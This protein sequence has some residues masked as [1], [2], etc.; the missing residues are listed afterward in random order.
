M[1][2]LMLSWEYPPRV[3]G[4]LGSH[5]AGLSRALAEVGVDVS[6]LTRGEIGVQRDDNG[7]H[8]VEVPLWG[9]LPAPEWGAWVAQ[10]NI[11]YL[12]AA[13]AQWAGDPPDLLHAHDWTVALTTR[14]LKHL[15]HRPLIATIHATEAGRNGGLSSP[16]NRYIDA[17]ERMLTYEA[18]RVIV[19]SRAMVAEVQA[20]FH[21]PEEKLAVIP[22]GVSL[23]EQNEF[24]MAHS[25]ATVLYM[26]RLTYE[27]GIHVLID[28]I[29]QIRHFFPD[30]QLLIAGDGPYRAQ[31]EAQAKATLDPQQVRFIGWVNGRQKSALLSQAAI[32]VV[33]SL[34]EPFGIVALEEMGAALPVVASR[35]GGLPEVIEEGVTGLLVPPGDSTALAEALTTLLR[36]PKWCETLGR[37]GRLRVL[38]H[39]SWHTVARETLQLYDSFLTKAN[40]PAVDRS[41]FV[42]RAPAY[43]PKAIHHA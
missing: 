7:V 6:V 39:F 32:A 35:V 43:F 8:V 10:A 38:Q 13:L 18:T 9:N 25:T 21:V 14:A 28:A 36:Q 23:V 2:L 26:G 3:N 30:V 33:P 16:L 5:I 40:A 37:A 22:N 1:H 29:G 41:T 31:L 17:V 42:G 15:W 11:A 12:E 4:G 27:K 24:P 19:C 20:L 34:Y